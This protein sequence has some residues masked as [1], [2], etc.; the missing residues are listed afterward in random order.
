MPGRRKKTGRGSPQ[1][2]LGYRLIE[3]PI[4]VGAGVPTA[5]KF[6]STADT[7]PSK[8]QGLRVAT[9]SVR[10][11]TSVERID[12]VAFTY[13]S[14]IKKTAKSRWS[15]VGGKTRGAIEI[16]AQRALET[17]GKIDDGKTA[18]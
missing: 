18:P 9:A 2:Y 8:S 1:A 4:V 13:A 12:G 6:E 15:R 7:A 11:Q 14:E 10:F 16:F 3:D 17:N 5:E